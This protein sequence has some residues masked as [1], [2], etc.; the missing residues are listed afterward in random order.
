MRPEIESPARTREIVLEDDML[1][2]PCHVV[3]GVP[4]PT[5]HWFLNDL[6]VD[7]SRVNIRSDNSLV[8]YSLDKSDTGVF[9]CK[10]TNS[11]GSDTI[12]VDVSVSSR[13]SINSDPVHVQF[14]DTIQVDVSVSSRTSI[15]SDTI[16]VDVS[17]SS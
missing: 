16:Q 3:Q 12:Q 4:I 9:T 1:V 2:L 8:V 5:I 15:N 14:S 17:V 11:E 7:K 6:P 13:T 10:A